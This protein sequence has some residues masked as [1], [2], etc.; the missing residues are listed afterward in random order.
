MVAVVAGNG[1][2][3][4]NTSLSILGGAGVSG[5]SVLGQGGARSFV[6][7]AT[8]NLV[9]QMQDEW[10]SGRG[11]DLQHVRT[12]NSLGELVDPDEDGWHWGYEQTVRLT[13]GTINQ[14]GSR[15]TRT[16]GDGHETV[17]DWN[18]SRYV[19]TEGSGAHDTLVYDPNP[20][21]P[22]NPQWAWTEGTTQLVETYS[23]A[24]SRLIKRTDT[25]GNSITFTHDSSGRLTGAKDTG[26]QQ[27]MQLTYAQFNGKTKL[28]KIETRALNDNGTLGSF[29]KQVE[30]GYLNDRLASVKTD[31]TPGNTAD[32][33][34]PAKNYFAF[35]TYNSA[36]RVEGIT[37]SDNSKVFFTYHADGRVATVK[38]N[39]AASTNQL[40][41]SYGTN[42]TTVTDGNGQ[43]WT[44]KYDAVTRQLTEILTPLVNGASLSTKFEYDPSGNVIRVTDANNKSV[45]YRY[46]ANG[47]RIQEQDALGNTVTRTFNALNQVVSETR[48]KTPDTDGN[49]NTMTAGGPLTTRYVYDSSSRLRFVVSAEGRVA[50]TRYGSSGNSSG[51]PTYAVRYTGGVYDVSGLSE[52]A[53]LTESQ[54]NS[55]AT[56]LADKSKAQITQF[57]YDLR[58]N[59]SRQTNYATVN[60]SGVGVLDA[61]ATMT[62]YVYDPHGQLV[63]TIAVRGANRDLPTILTS[64][65]YDGL[66]RVVS[67][68]SGGVTQTTVYD[69]TNRQIQV[70]LAATGLVETRSYDT[71]GRLLS[72]SQ[73][74]DSTTRQTRYVYNNADQLRMVRDAQDSRRFSFYDAA[75]RLA[76][77]VDSTGA[78]TGFEYKATGQVAKQTQFATRIALSVMNGWY[79]QTSN[80]VTKL[81]LAI[82]TDV[83]ADPAKDRI[84]TYGYDDA[85]RLTTATDA[86]NVVTTTTYDGL[87][88]VTMTQ[89]GDRV[90]RYLYDKDSRKIGMVDALGFLTEYKYDAGG[91][92]IETVRYS[93]RSPGI[94]N[95][96]APVWIGVTNQTATGGRLFE[97]RAPAYDADGD[98]LTFSVVGTLPAWLTFDASTA[99]LR[100]TPPTTL[101]DYDVTLRAADGR[102]KTSDVTVRIS[103]ANS[104]PTWSD[105]PDQA[106]VPSST[107]WSLTLPAAADNGPST[108]LTYS[109]RSPL[110]P[111]VIFDAAQRKL[112]GQPMQPLPGLYTLTARV[113]DAQGQSVDKSFTLSVQGDWV[114]DSADPGFTP[115]P[116]QEL[117]AGQPFSFAIPAARQQG[118]SYDVLAKPSWLQFNPT[119]RV[120]SGTPPA[121]ASFA[122]VTLV[123]RHPSG[124]AMAL[125]FGVNVRSQSPVWV[126]LPPLDAVAGSAVNYTPPAAQDPENEALTYSVVSGLPAGLSPDQATGRISGTPR[127]V[128]FYTIVL[129]ATDP[130]GMSVDATVSLQVRSTASAPTQLPG[131]DALEQ[132]RPAN[133]SGLHAYVYYDGQGRVI[134]SV[135]E[136]GFL[137]E[138]IYNDA[139][140]AQQSVRYMTAVTV[141]S[142]DTL[143]AL[144][145]V[146]GQ[147]QTTTTEYDVL[148]RVFRVKRFDNVTTRLEYDTAGRLAREV[149]DAGGTQERATRTRYNAFGET[150]GTVGGVGDA[151]LGVNPTRQ[152]IDAAI[153]TFGLRYEYDSLGRRSRMIDANGHATVLFY[154][155]ENRLTHTV[156]AERE[157]SET[158]Y[159]RFGSVTSTRQYATGMTPANFAGLTGG[160]A[161]QLQ[162]KLPLATNEDTVTTY[163]YDR[164]GLLVEQTDGEGFATRRHYDAY[165]QLA[166][167][168]RAILNGKTATTQFDYDLRGGLL[169][170][171][172]DVGGINLNSRS[173]YDAF[174]RVIRS[175]DAA[176]KITTTRYLDSGRSIEV[177]D[178]LNRTARGEY[179]AYNRVLKRVDALG[180]A[181]LYTYHDEAGGGFD[182]R[183]PEGL[184]VKTLKNAHGEVVSVSNQRGSTSYEYDK[185]GQLKKVTDALGRTIA[186]NDY[187]DSGRLF[188][189]TDA[190]GTVTELSYDAVN[191]VLERRVDPAGLNLKTT[192]AFDTSGRQIQVTEAAGTTAARVTS[193]TYDRSGRLRQVV[194]DPAGLKLSTRYSYDGLGNTI[195]VERGTLTDPKQQVTLY[196]FD[197]LG[198]RVKEIAAPS[199]DFGVGAPG[200]RDLTTQYRYDIAGRVSRRIDANGNST[201]YVYDAAGQLSYTIN[202]LGEVSQSQYDA[203]GRLIHT[204]HYHTRL[205]ADLLAGFG[206]V[207]GPFTPPAVHQRDQRSYSVYDKDGRVRFTVQAEIANSWSISENRYDVAGNL[208]ESRRYDKFLLEARIDALTTPDSPG[209][210]LPEITAELTELGYS[211]GG[212]TL[213]KIR[214]THFAYDA[215]NRLRFTVDALGSVS[216]NEYD[217]AGAVV[218]TVRYAVQPALSAYDENTINAAVDRSD[219]N[220]QVSA[221]AYDVA[222]RLRFSVKVLVGNVQGMSTQDLVS[223]QTYDALG[224][225]VES[226]AYAR[227]VNLM[228]DYGA[229]NI[230][231]TVTTD[232][233][234]RR[235]AAAYDA[236]GRQVYS[237]RV[238]SAGAAGQHMVS[239]LEYDALGH[240]VKSTAYAAAIGLADFSKATLDTAT[241]SAASNPANRKTELVYDAAGRQRFAVA[242][243]GA[244]GETVYDALGQVIETRQFDLRVDP[245]T[246]RTEAALAQVRAQR[247]V[248]DGVRLTRGEKY[249]YDRAGRVLSTT[250]ANGNA[251]L[252]VYNGLGDRTSY[253]N[254]NGATWTYEYDRQGRVFREIS[255]QVLVQLSTE[256]APSSRSLET[257]LYRDAFGSLVKR[258]EANDTVDARVTDYAY[259]TLGRLTLTVLPGWYDPAGGKVENA[260]GTG[261]FRREIQLAY[262]ALG[263]AARTR[264]RTGLSTFQYEYK[265][266][267]ALG[268]LVH[269]VDA[270]NHVTAF[271]YTSF[272]EQKTVTRHSVAMA[273]APGNGS[274]WTAAE[275]ATRVNSD[276][277]ARTVTTSYDNLGRK[278]EVK[279]NTGSYYFNSSGAGFNPLSAQTVF[280]AP[281]TKYEY[282]VF[283]DLHRESAKIDAD[284]WRETWHYY[285]TMGREIRTIEELRGPREP[286]DRPTGY[287]TARS[288]DALGNLKLTIEYASLANSGASGDFTLPGT[289]FEANDDRIT[290]YEY[291]ALNRKIKTERYNLQFADALGNL[292]TLSR[293]SSVVTQLVRYDSMGNVVLAGDGDGR[294]TRFE[295]NALGQ[296]IKVI[297][298]PRATAAANAVDPFQNQVSVAP[299]TTL[300]LNAFGNVVATERNPGNGAGLIVRTRQGYD[301]AGNAI[302]STDAKEYVKYRQYDYAGRVIRETQD[303]S[304][305]LGSDLGGSNNHTLERRY[306]YDASGRQ[307]AVLDAYFEGGTRRQSGQHSL[308]NAFGE[309]VE[310]RRVSGSY[311]TALAGLSSA[312]LATYSYDDSGH[313]LSKTAAAGV[314]RYFYD[315]LGHV[316]RQEQRGNFSDVDGTPTR[317]T[318]TAYDR[319]GRA[320]S[321]R[322][323]RFMAY[324]PVGQADMVQKDATPYTAQLYDRWGNVTLRSAGG[325]TTPN[326]EYDPSQAT[327]TTYAYNHDN[328]LIAEH[329]PRA[330]ASRT[331]GSFY[332]TLVTH[333]LRYD[334]KGQVVLEQDVVD[335]AATPQ[336]EATVLRRRFKQYDRAGQL[337][338]QTDATGYTTLYAYDAHG[339]R[340]GTR[341]A[342]GT[343]FVDTFDKNGNLTQHS[344]LRQRINGAD[345]PY[346]GSGTPFAR[347][348]TEHWYDQANRRY[349]TE[350]KLETGGYRTTTRHDE[351]NLVRAQRDI[352]GAVTT[353]GYD[354][355]GNKT[356]ETDAL[357]N[358][359]TWVYSDANDYTVGRLLRRTVGGLLTTYEYDDFAQVTKED[360]AGGENERRYVYHWNGMVQ[361]IDDVS[362]VGTAGEPGGADY[363]FTNDSTR[364]DYTVKGELAHERFTRAGEQ[365]VRKFNLSRGGW[366]YETEGL[367][368]ITRVTYTKYDSLG[369]MATVLTPTSTGHNGHKLW[370]LNYNYDE[371]GNIRHIGGSYRLLGGDSSQ[372]INHWFT[373]DAE[374][375]MTIADGVL[376]NAQIIAGETG[377]KIG[378]D[379]LGRRTTVEKLLGGNDYTY[380]PD[381]TNDL[382]DYTDY[383]WREYRVESYEY[384]DLGHLRIIWQKISYRNTEM[385]VASHHQGWLPAPEYDHDTA[386]YFSEYR[387]ND[388]RGFVGKRET[389]SAVRTAQDTLQELEGVPI[390]ETTTTSQYRSDGQLHTQT[391]TNQRDTTHQSDAQLTFLYDATGRLTQHFYRQGVA[392]TPQEFLDTYEYTYSMENG[393]LKEKTI[394]VTRQGGN[395]DAKPGNTTNVYDARGRL[396]KVVIENSQ[397][398]TARTFSYDSSDHIIVVRQSGYDTNGMPQL[399][400]QEHFHANGRQVGTLG[401][402]KLA[403][404]RFSFAYT[405]ISAGQANPGTYAVHAGDTLAGMAQAVYGDSALWYL[406]ADANG[407]GFGP[408]QTLPSVEVGKSYRIPNVVGSHNNAN[409]FQPYNPADIIGNTMPSPG[410]PVP[411]E[412][413]SGAAAVVATVVVVAIT[414][415]VSTIATMVTTPYVGPV[416]GGGIGGAAG[417]LAGQTTGWSLGLQDDIDWTQVGVAGAQGVIGGGLG[418]LV[419]GGDLGT[420][421]A[422]AGATN[423][424]NQVVSQAADNFEGWSSAAGAHSGLFNLGLSLAGAAGGQY[425]DDSPS[426]YFNFSGAA[427]QMA[428]A[429]FNP[430]SGWLFNDR[431]RDWTNIATQAAGAFTGVV[432]DA[433]IAYAYAQ[434]Q[435]SQYEAAVGKANAQRDRGRVSAVSATHPVFAGAGGPTP[436]PTRDEEAQKAE[437]T[438]MLGRDV[439]DSSSVPITRIVDVDGKSVSQIAGYYQCAPDSSSEIAAACAIPQFGLEWGLENQFIE[440]L[441]FKD[442]LTFQDPLEFRSKQLGV[443][444]LSPDRFRTKYDYE[445]YTSRGLKIVR[446]DRYYQRLS[447]NHQDYRHALLNN[448][449]D[450]LTKTANMAAFGQLMAIGPAMELGVWTGVAGLATAFLPTVE[451]IAVSYAAQT[452]VT[453]VTGSEVAGLAAGVLAGGIGLLGKQPPT[454][455]EIMSEHRALTALANRGTTLVPQAQPETRLLAAGDTTLTPATRVSGVYEDAGVKII[456]NP[457]AVDTRSPVVNPQAG[458]LNC[459]PSARVVDKGLET[460]RFAAVGDVPAEPF[461]A[462][463][464]P[465]RMG[466]PDAD[467]IMYMSP[468]RAQNAID[469]ANDLSRLGHGAKGMIVGRRELTLREQLARPGETYQA[470]VWNAVNYRGE[471]YHLEGQI[472]LVT[473]PD[474]FMMYLMQWDE[475]FFI[476]TGQVKFWMPSGYMRPP[477]PPAPAPAVLDNNWLATFRW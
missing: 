336:N 384:D 115:M 338:A 299:V 234:D 204:R 41:F 318:E 169:S 316:T 210:S 441:S 343:V 469:L 298:A 473:H 459:A 88:R 174:G 461:N 198:R 212:S 17:Y 85:G 191:R 313:L 196:E 67:S 466:Y 247:S 200:T 69:G 405:P 420:R 11:S 238:L 209:I 135:D 392:N 477:V 467:L 145:S 439:V 362:R 138:T 456:L 415:A 112:T 181:T 91:R 258:I 126:P 435:R 425:L 472:G 311:D 315:L 380:D 268:R 332:E 55:W 28:W 300:T 29:V 284:S 148:G 118:F 261:R 128:G 190:R 54:L 447:E 184:E 58:G 329:L 446:N 7:A 454:V 391:I 327:T 427:G 411:P 205:N 275:V 335:N 65:G 288:Y 243:D 168:V 366:Y 273:G 394:T 303:I 413:C 272:D 35:Y 131:S 162:N 440:I 105:L 269:D 395:P 464:F 259:D 94:A 224:Q 356:S 33:S 277:A 323:P 285:D 165:G 228:G 287:H 222:G 83:A 27:E 455:G 382:P 470:H 134:G 2:G 24:T 177:T 396:Q 246:P 431:S 201:W 381:P 328:Q 121:T 51:L 133:A 414:M 144:R 74:G 385:D 350:E 252:N 449:E 325:Y 182:V 155:T 383:R 127:A 132:W 72:V 297:E 263:N 38:E 146:S 223:G 4:F 337:S 87:S 354:A 119:T 352:S 101:I 270:L 20:Q 214:R 70:T 141:S 349:S 185:N 404:A 114:A 340:V 34:D 39:S 113:T 48:Y 372:G 77:T 82:G 37:Q 416:V 458:E 412:Q 443:E 96:A 344:V 388:L 151:T 387:E 369:R 289:P 331:D 305:V 365:D 351:R 75:G 292:I 139:G 397:E 31:L 357:T 99:T 326:G 330:A 149:R 353:Y 60:A 22:Q 278:I 276:T 302:S 255:P 64:Y 59:L 36:G 334:L 110:P 62:E 175:V 312:K 358:T 310:E 322:L 189:T 63:Q 267:D 104:A 197:S 282:N 90:T 71:R 207:L 321:Q 178:P 373:Y 183:T 239:K 242:A 43:A 122:T 410:L 227:V 106:V 57:D 202:G 408:D 359:Q 341:N 220:N 156:N 301:A 432:V 423:V 213:A 274:H 194:V 153:A 251:D 465:E 46:D 125:S 120:L 188:Q 32:D 92:L 345:Q 379:A 245:Q 249:T 264:T 108:Q 103:V 61:A 406:I 13:A 475:T 448:I 374:G 180:Q 450:Q 409:T 176:G 347:V 78:V 167:E 98:S 290:G 40:S 171:T 18:N 8:G 142:G 1:L 317:I 390:V 386:A 226:T 12:Y 444:V 241:Q 433:G 377:N 398:S 257:R 233:S 45:V 140:N 218:K 143:A 367:S 463:L 253:R 97:Y 333:E 26:S 363:L 215:N 434:L 9:L 14:A 230:A 438:W 451:A 107:G 81:S 324:V 476:H 256:S 221:F 49:S 79:D 360:Y 389:Y 25:S 152:A 225:V 304:V 399:G 157:V 355:L 280:D 5:Q 229:A 102:G 163:A 199:A 217:A 130:R 309:V 370:E 244:L 368:P 402:G 123:A 266:Y 421:L 16:D 203:N 161:S 400:A 240:L 50:E 419:K 417:N 422:R 393:G 66:G 235:S 52:T 124:A 293:N 136:R 195:K 193:Y 68:T 376:E 160:A 471:R 436:G 468:L 314:T 173:T 192:Y 364:Y 84:T 339:N 306:S 159:D 371:L 254:R 21:D 361:R 474:D 279:Q 208:I 403:G 170:A 265:T 187:D 206:D 10:L 319:M 232:P 283:G 342:L 109:L 307:I 348:L 53:S 378:Y 137:S 116:V 271:T 281:I 147:A 250:D 76:F 216:E 211:D 129:R 453:D 117:R 93:E 401:T 462:L 219:A 154:D 296:T 80:T 111:G 452:V 262:D 286:G 89:T 179:D 158:V 428:H 237:V 295:Y 248:G 86:A 44:Y 291:D 424:A 231:A 6:N 430:Q 460:G 19:S 42:Q 236:A 294:D 308:F 437:E 375:R 56:G 186:R 429:A 445:T 418:K 166:A 15:V 442:P 457:R 320:I 73:A 172:A 3:L 95:T 407:L 47:N 426:H 164:R 150:T 23:H 30:Y 346:V 100:G 260:S